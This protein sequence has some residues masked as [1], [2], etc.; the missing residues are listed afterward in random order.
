MEYVR[1]IVLL[2]KSGSGKSSLGNTIFGDRYAFTVDT[3]AN[4]DPSPCRAV[5]RTVHR[6]TI[7]VI[8]TPGLF[9]TND[10]VDSFSPEIMHCL[11]HCAPGAHAFILVL[12]KENFTSQE[13]DVVDLILQHFSPEALR[14]TTIVFTHGD[15]L[16][17]GVRIDGWAQQNPYLRNLLQQCGN[18]CHVVDN[19]RWEG[20]AANQYIYRNNQNQVLDLLNTID[21]ANG[22]SYFPNEL[23][24]N[25]SLWQRFRSAPI[26]VQ[27]CAILGVG[28]VMYLLYSTVPWELVS[29]WV[30][31]GAKYGVGWVGW[32]EQNVPNDEEGIKR[33]IIYLIPM[34]QLFA[35]IRQKTE[36]SRKSSWSCALI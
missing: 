20:Q 25:K 32:V 7:T 31:E 34:Y 30:I 15:D 10:P 3:S 1:R 36:E 9:N 14:F 19:V 8:D 23:M 4:S 6:K 33:A 16:N 11:E 18:R 27:I 28:V 17:E 24:Q 22:G 35:K 13:C 5:T 26:G 21:R 12:K 2:G 29:Q